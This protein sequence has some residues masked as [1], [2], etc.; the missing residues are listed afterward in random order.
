MTMTFLPTR[1]SSRGPQSI[2]AET[3][4]TMLRVDSGAPN[5]FRSAFRPASPADKTS[6]P[7]VS[8]GL[9]HL[10]PR[11]GGTLSRTREPGTVEWTRSIKY[12]NNAPLPSLCSVV[13]YVSS[14]LCLCV[15]LSPSLSL[16]LSSTPTIYLSL[17]YLSIFLSLCFSSPTPVH[18]SPSCLYS[19]N[20]FLEY[21]VVRVTFL[22]SR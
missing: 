17:I 8:D 18:L 7:S 6:G 2:R 22:L 13:T 1:T 10:F 15:S 20:F 16:S 12:Q 19:S 11:G 5:G 9:L 4:I 14:F 21:T 3:P